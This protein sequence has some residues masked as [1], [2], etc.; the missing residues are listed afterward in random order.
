MIVW[1]DEII[2]NAFDLFF[3]SAIHKNKSF[4][5]PNSL[6]MLNYRPISDGEE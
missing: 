5:A 2:H 4:T 6:E 1:L 3:Q